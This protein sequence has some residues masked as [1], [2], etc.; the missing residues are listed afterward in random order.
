MRWMVAAIVLC[1]VGSGAVAYPA[2]DSPFGICATTWSHAGAGTTQFDREG[3][4]RRLALVKELGAAWERCDFWW[5]RLEP[6]PGQYQF[7]DYDFAVEQYGR[8]GVNLLAILCYSSAWYGRPPDTDEERGRYAD[9]VAAMVARYKGKVAA[10]E[11]WNEPNISMFW[12]PQPNVEDYAAMLKE[13]YRAAKRAD[14]RCVI[15][16]AV[17]AG[18]GLNFIE[19]LFELGCGDFMDVIS[20]HPYQGHPPEQIMPE[21]LEALKALMGRYHFRKPI[22]IT[23]VGFQTKPAEHGVVT[24][25]EQADWLVRTNVLALAA[26]VEKVFWFNL[27]DWSETWGLIR[28]DWSEKDSYWAYRMMTRMLGRGELLRRLS[29]PEGCWMFAFRAPRAGD[30]AVIVAWRTSPAD[31]ETVVSVPTGGSRVLARGATGERVEGQATNDR[32]TF[33]LSSSPVFI[34]R[35]PTA[36]LDRVRVSP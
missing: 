9:W 14:P 11:I 25:R 33:A 1:A 8:L 22:W 6:E 2:P 21:R 27:Q 30:R 20:V 15:V 17:T 35:V 34:Y 19:R 4:A 7:A 32:V 24:E 5:S 12:Q 28:T 31:D 3:P 29:A 36:E 18:T 26:G 16:G 13:A 23:E 10:W